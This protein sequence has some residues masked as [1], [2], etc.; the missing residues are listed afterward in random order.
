MDGGGTDEGV[1][2]VGRVADDKR[3]V[4]D[5]LVANGVWIQEPGG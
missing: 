5:G 1:A 3:L 2:A 4:D